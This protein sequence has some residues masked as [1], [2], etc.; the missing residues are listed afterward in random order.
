MRL[1]I[2]RSADSR[3][4]GATVRDG[5][6][7]DGV[8]VTEPAAKPPL[9]ERRKTALRL[10]IAREAVRLFTSQGVTGTTGDQIAQ[11][12]G[13]STRTL[14]RHFPSKEGCVRP[15]LTSG[16]DAATDALRHWP[17]GIPLLEFLTSASRHGNLPTADP[18]VL[19][20]I[21]MTLN[22]PA[23]RAVWLQAHDD[24]LPVLAE[25]LARRSGRSA[26]ELRVKVHAATINGALRAA[27]EDF[28]VRYAE[29]PDASDGELAACL[30][31]ALRAATE[32]LPY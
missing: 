23:L 30:H 6:P 13:I 14:W 32:G 7:A 21:R 4:G 16:L 27:A 15:L 2:L 9:G 12:V 17:P 19:D 26:D 24:A 1:A 22:E 25:L 5:V 20:L 28:A 11:A 18:A 29:D 31:A 10:E 8:A 3:G